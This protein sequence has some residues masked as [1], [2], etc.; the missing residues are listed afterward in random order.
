VF[1]RTRVPPTVQWFDLA[2]LADAWTAHVVNQRAFVLS[3]KRRVALHASVRDEGGTKRDEATVPGLHPLLP[4]FSTVRDEGTKN[5]VKGGGGELG[6]GK[7]P[8][9]LPGPPPTAREPP[10]RPSVR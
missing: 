6:G 9:P 5:L 4:S 1:G 8:L 2:R 10:P 3:P 7:P